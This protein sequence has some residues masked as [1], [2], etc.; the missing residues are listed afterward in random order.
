MTEIRRSQRVHF[1]GGSGFQLAGIIDQPTSTPIAWALFTHCFTCTK[2]IKLI[3]RISRSLAERGYAVLRYDLTGLGHSHGDFARTNFTTNQLDLLAAAR[4]LSD[5]HQP[6][7]FLIGHSFG[8]AVSLSVA[9]RIESV[10]GVASLAA[11]S[12][13]HHLANLLQRLNSQILDAGHGHVS[14]GGIS[15]RIERQM[16]ENFR[17]VHLSEI[18]QRLSKSVLLVHSPDDETLEYAHA[19]RLY[20]F[21]TQRSTAEVPP[22]P[23]TLVCLAEVD[24]LFSRNAADLSFTADLVAGWFKRVLDPG[25]VP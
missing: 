23:T 7:A 11:P 21:L 12:D 14:I 25:V 20:Q 5:H 15:H 17:S 19:L 6:P 2:D 22:A 4:Y 13:T 9:G 24:H 16:L 1:E 8:G 3:V 10:L 18:L